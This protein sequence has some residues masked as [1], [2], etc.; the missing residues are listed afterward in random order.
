MPHVDQR[1]GRILRTKAGRANQFISGGKSGCTQDRCKRRQGQADGLCDRLLQDQLFPGCKKAFQAEMVRPLQGAGL[2][3]PSELRAPQRA[4]ARCAFSS[5]TWMPLAPFTTWVTRKSAARLQSV[6]ASS[7][8]NPVRAQMNLIM[9]RSAITTASS[10]SGS[11][12][13]VMK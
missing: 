13:I 8:D 3:C 5:I 11:N 6:Y 2:N 7:W 10:R 12:A 9:S 1:D 4:R